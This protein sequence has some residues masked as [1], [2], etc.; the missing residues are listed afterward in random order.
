EPPQRGWVALDLRAPERNRV[1]ARK[2]CKVR[3]PEESGARLERL[4]AAL[5]AEPPIHVAEVDVHGRC[6]PE[7]QH[8]PQDGKIEGGAVE[9]DQRAPV[10]R[11]LAKPGQVFKEAGQPVAIE[12]PRHGD[13][14]A[15]R[16]DVEE[17]GIVDHLR[18]KTPVLGLRE[19]AGEEVQ[20]A[21]R[22]LAQ[23]GRDSFAQLGVEARREYVASLGQLRPAP[24]ARE[25]ELPL[26]Q[27]PDPR[28]VPERSGDHE[29]SSSASRTRMGTSASQNGKPGRSRRETQRIWSQASGLGSSPAWSLHRY[30]ASSTC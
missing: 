3:W 14:L 8:P 29:S 19:A 20:I 6:L 23:G 15:G 4:Q 30:S 11:P 18:Q 10:A 9:R 22:Q 25:P 1:R 7:R 28:D 24:H 27:R 2:P 16:L 21:L 26:A 13:L 12:H 17:G 5:L